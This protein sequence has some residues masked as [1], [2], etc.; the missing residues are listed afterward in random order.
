MVESIKKITNKKSKLPGCIIFNE[1]LTS[2]NFNQV[3]MDGF[4]RNLE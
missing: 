2:N 3:L 4:Q 1:Y